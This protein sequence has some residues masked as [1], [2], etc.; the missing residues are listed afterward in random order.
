MSGSSLVTKGLVSGGGAAV[1]T[2][3]SLNLPPGFGTT[4]GT[5]LLKQDAHVVVAVPTAINTCLM[6]A[7]NITDNLRAQQSSNLTLPS[8]YK[9]AY[10]VANTTDEI[11]LVRE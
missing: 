5:P 4:P 2:E 3:V 10:L 1:A 8:L 11:A 7:E 9:R 6:A